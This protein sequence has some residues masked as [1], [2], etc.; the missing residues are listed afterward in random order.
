MTN[1]INIRLT[2]TREVFYNA[3]SNWGIYAFKTNQKVDLKLNQYNNYTLKGK[4]MRLQLDQ[5][6]NAT[7]IETHDKKN[8]WGY[9][10]KSIYQD[11]PSDIGK[12]KLFLS[13]ILTDEQVRN[14]Y[15]V[16]TY[17]EELIIQFDFDKIPIEFK[18]LDR[19]LH[20]WCLT[21]HKMQGSANKAIIAIADR[22]HKFQLNANLIYTAFTRPKE[23]LIIVT[24][25]ETLNFAMRKVANLQR[26]TF[27]CEMLKNK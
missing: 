11:I 5:E 27:L 10:I 22:S 21:M 6:Y 12:Q 19:L 9:E 14:I 16:Y 24:Q 25:A 1:S 4:T 26:N 8:G 20:A 18:K 23:F 13:Y 2:P 7:V 15:K 17:A 3:D